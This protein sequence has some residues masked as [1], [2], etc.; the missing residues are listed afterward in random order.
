MIVGA[1]FS[2]AATI[3]ALFAVPLV[4]A[5]YVILSLAAE[6]TLH[7]AIVL[8]QASQ[9]NGAA[10]KIQGLL[11]VDKNG[12]VMWVRIDDIKIDSQTGARVCIRATRYRP[13]S[14]TLYLAF[15]VGFCAAHSG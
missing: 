9:P 12:R 10:G 1:K 14:F 4:F 8:G 7:P 3:A 2:N 11:Q 13:T 6:V 5:A 15:P